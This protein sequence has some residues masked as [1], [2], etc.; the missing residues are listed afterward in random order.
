MPARELGP[1]KIARSSHVTLRLNDGLRNNMPIRLPE[2]N[3]CSFC[4]AVIYA[5]ERSAW[6]CH[7][8]GA[9]WFQLAKVRVTTLDDFRNGLISGRDLTQR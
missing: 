3:P 4:P 9:N 2:T 6:S 8:R 5:A 1:V 7:S